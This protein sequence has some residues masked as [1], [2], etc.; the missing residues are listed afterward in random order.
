MV[1]DLN[2]RAHLDI[3]E[4]TR[5]VLWGGNGGSMSGP[6]LATGV[7][8]GDTSLYHILNYY[9]EFEPYPGGSAIRYNGPCVVR[10]SRLCRNWNI[11]N[12][13]GDWGEDLLEPGPHYDSDAW[14]WGTPP[15]EEQEIRQGGWG[16]QAE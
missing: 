12:W 1:Q 11:D 7:R 9:S 14:T 13:R 8:Y 15:P 4:E 3:P 2:I 5:I 10:H 16:A 6:R